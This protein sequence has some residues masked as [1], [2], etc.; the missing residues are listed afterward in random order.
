MDFLFILHSV[1]R[2]IIIA[3]AALT[4]FKFAIGWAVNASFKGMDRGLAASFSGLLDVQVL[5]GLV[6]FL[7]SGFTGA[8][9][10]GY[11]WEHMVIMI[12]AAALGHVPSRLK[13]L[14]DKQR[15]FYSVVAILGAL[16]LVYVGVMRLPGGWTR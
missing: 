10:P 3:V 13:A 12:I 8:G 9:F 15:F 4:V 5:L 14:G 2:W 6:F 7:W 16:A 1:L 11:R